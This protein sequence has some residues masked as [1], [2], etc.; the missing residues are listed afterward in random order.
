MTGRQVAGF[1]HRSLFPSA[2]SAGLGSRGNA[3][4]QAMK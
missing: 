2:S 3:F 1:L 4:R